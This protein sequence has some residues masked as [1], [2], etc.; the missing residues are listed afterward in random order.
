MRFL[1]TLQEQG[2]CFSPFHKQ[3]LRRCQGNY[4]Q[5]YYNSEGGAIKDYLT[6]KGKH[7]D[8]MDDWR[9][10]PSEA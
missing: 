1:C 2:Y 3:F 4:L 6:L 10:K 8:S 5:E 9:G 7:R